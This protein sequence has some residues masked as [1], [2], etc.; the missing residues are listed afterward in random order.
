MFWYTACVHPLDNVIEAL[1]ERRRALGLSQLDVEA[2]AALPDGRLGQWESPNRTRYPSIPSLLAWSA[3]LGCRLV[4]D[5][6]PRPQVGSGRHDI[7]FVA[8][9]ADAGVTIRVST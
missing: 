8:R 9:L 1:K 7:A 5:G 3:A 6:Q 2:E 4:I